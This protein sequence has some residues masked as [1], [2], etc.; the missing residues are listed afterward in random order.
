VSSKKLTKET[1][2][3]IISLHKSEHERAL[4]DLYL[5]YPAVDWWNIYNEKTTEQRLQLFAL[6]PFTLFPRPCIYHK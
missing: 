1:V 3:D 2:G 6:E 4:Y 5:R